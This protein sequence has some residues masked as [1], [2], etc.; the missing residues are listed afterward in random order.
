M[1]TAVDDSIR[2]K[3]GKPKNKTDQEIGRKDL[4]GSRSQI[5]GRTLRTGCA[6]PGGVMEIDLPGG[7]AVRKRRRG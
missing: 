1:M 5:G 6:T 3:T 7:G 4:Q 2:S